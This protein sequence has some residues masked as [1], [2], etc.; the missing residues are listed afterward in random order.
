MKKYSNLLGL[1]LIFGLIAYVLFYDHIPGIS[2]F[3]GTICLLLVLYIGRDTGRKVTWY[4]YLLSF[5]M[6]WLAGSTALLAAPELLVLNILGLLVLTLVLAVELGPDPVSSWNLKNYIFTIPKIPFQILG[7]ALKNIRQLTISK[8]SHNPKA[9]KRQAIVRGLLLALPLVV[10]F[11]L[12]FRSANP[13]FDEFLGR[14]FNFSVNINLQGSLT[15]IVLVAFITLGLLG[16]V[17]S[18]KQTKGPA[19]STE[20]KSAG[21][22]G[23]TFTTV[24]GSLFLLFLAFQAGYIFG[25]ES[26]ISTSGYSYA[27]YLHRGFAETII[28]AMLTTITL[29]IVEKSYGK[30]RQGN[31]LYISS[32]AVMLVSTIII[33]LSTLYRMYIYQQAY[34]LS[35]QRL[36]V[37][38]FST[39]VFGT[40]LILAYKLYNH[41]SDSFYVNSAAIA[42]LAIW[43]IFLLCNPHALI[44][45]N[46]LQ[47]YLDGKQLDTLYVQELSTDAVPAI[48]NTLPL[49]PQESQ[50]LIKDSVLSEIKF[51]LGTNQDWQS[52]NLSEARAK[53]M[54]GNI[55]LRSLEEIYEL[56]QLP[57]FIPPFVIPIDD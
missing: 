43:S 46:N 33:T 50:Q 53:K 47:R 31:R 51:R 49:L 2:V 1:S 24:L 7:F 17:N 10:I 16:L 18:I 39:W 37:G 26:N 52:W 9:I 48:I 5:F 29:I 35:M 32:V 19:E 56:S 15:T 41:K 20:D 57:K 36:F 11:S 42:G 22:E 34:G 28:S 44:T 21:M 3:L 14:I 6:L 12:L 55:P 25:G 4:A 40:L 54:L 38:I 23:A 45:K 13:I 30:L 8:A 27:E